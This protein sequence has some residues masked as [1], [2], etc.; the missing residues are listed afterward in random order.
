MYYMRKHERSYLANIQWEIVNYILEYLHVICT[1]ALHWSPVGNN[2]LL[3]YAVA[4]AASC[5]HHC[6]LSFA[7]ELTDEFN[8]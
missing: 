8:L 4:A 5:H 6:H 7:T 1:H 3:G 2:S